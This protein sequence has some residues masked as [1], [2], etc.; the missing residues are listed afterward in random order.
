M[1]TYK[2]LFAV[3]VGILLVTEANAFYDPNKGRWL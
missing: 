1:K 3:L 2:L